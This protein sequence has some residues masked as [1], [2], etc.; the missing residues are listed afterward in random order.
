MTAERWQR[1]KEV[2]QGALDLDAG[3]RP[4]FLDQ[5][6]ADDLDLRLR[7]EALLASDENIGE[8]LA[9]PAIDLA[10]DLGAGGSGEY[11]SGRRVGRWSPIKDLYKQVADLPV[12]ERPAFL[13]RVCG[14]DE[15]LRRDVELLLVGEREAGSLLDNPVM[16]GR[17]Y[18]AQTRDVPAI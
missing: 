2:F 1:V 9:R 17:P 6:C 12:A 16:R 3:E 13:N 14:D 10:G 18:N 5:A 11:L 15:E 7:V 4:T 8:F